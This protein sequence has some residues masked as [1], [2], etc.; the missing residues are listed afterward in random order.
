ML[1]SALTVPQYDCIPGNCDSDI[2]YESD[3][4]FHDDIDYAHGRGRLDMMT[5]LRSDEPLV[6]CQTA[7]H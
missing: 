7:R 3:G 1:T 5:N 6:G 4:D 2:D